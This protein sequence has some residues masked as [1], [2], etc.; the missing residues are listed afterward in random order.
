MVLSLFQLTIPN[1]T[2]KENGML[3]T[4]KRSIAT[5]LL[6]AGLVL[7]LSAE[8]VQAQQNGGCQAMQNGQTTSSTGTTGTGQTALPTGRA[9]RTTGGAGLQAAALRQVQMARA[10]QMQAQ[11]SA[12]QQQAVLQAQRN[13]LQAQTSQLSTLRQQ[14]A[15]LARQNA[16]LQTAYD[17]QLL[18]LPPDLAVQTALR[19]VRTSR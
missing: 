11:M 16:V 3:S 9:L 15:A 13:S 10:M 4:I 18:G 6:P 8:P 7:V 19:Q 2:S 14:R 17:L 12:L 1:H 5:A